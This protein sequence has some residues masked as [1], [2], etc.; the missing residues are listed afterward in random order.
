M[1][2]ARI[3]SA[4]AMVRAAWLNLFLRYLAETSED[5]AA[6]AIQPTEPL[7]ALAGQARS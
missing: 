3:V 6:S 7:T 1:M 2:G 4:R 5:D